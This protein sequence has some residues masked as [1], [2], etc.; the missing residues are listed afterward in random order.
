MHAYVC[1]RKWASLRLA[2]DCLMFMMNQE[3]I[4]WEAIQMNMVAFTVR[5]LLI[6][7]SDGVYIIC[8]EEESACVLTRDRSFLL[9]RCS[10]AESRACAGCTIC[11]CNTF[12]SWEVTLAM[13][14]LR[15]VSCLLPCMPQFFLGHFQWVEMDLLHEQM[16]LLLWSTISPRIPYP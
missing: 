11:I 3:S 6:H 13:M 16:M 10:C 7:C 4:W 8:L 5:N 14:V 2:K 15:L 12:L 9:K 1:V